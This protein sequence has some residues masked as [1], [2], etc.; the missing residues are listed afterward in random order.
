VICVKY[1]VHIGAKEVSDRIADLVSSFDVKLT[2]PVKLKLVARAFSVL[3]MIFLEKGEPG[4]DSA[5]LA[6]I[7]QL[8]STLIDRYCSLRYNRFQ[9]SINHRF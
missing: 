7:K 3:T 8:F 6:K 2:S 5:S 9:I 4:A 1:V